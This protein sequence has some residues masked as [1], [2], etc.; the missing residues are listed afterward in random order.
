MDRLADI[1]RSHNERSGWDSC[2]IWQLHVLNNDGSGADGTSFP[3]GHVAAY[4]GTDRDDGVVS[5]VTVMADMAAVVDHHV[6]AKLGIRANEAMSA[7]INALPPITSLHIS[8]FIQNIDKHL[9]V[10]PLKRCDTVQ[11]HTDVE[12]DADADDQAMTLGYHL[13]FFTADLLT[14]VTDAHQ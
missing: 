6:V 11:R 9:P 2:F 14:L 13:F 10:I 7:D 4:L 3:Q 5:D 1:A 8:R 12:T